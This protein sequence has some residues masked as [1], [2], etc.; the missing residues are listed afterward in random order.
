MFDYHYEYALGFVVMVIALSL[1]MALMM[2]NGRTCSVDQNPAL[3]SSAR[4]TDSD[5]F[6]SEI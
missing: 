6:M 1:E 2:M 4:I 3:K 5:Y